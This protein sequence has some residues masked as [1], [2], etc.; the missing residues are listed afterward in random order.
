MNYR[1]SHKTL[2][3]VGDI[4]WFLGQISA[5]NRFKWCVWVTFYTVFGPGFSSSFQLYSP[6]ILV[7]SVTNLLEQQYLSAG[8]I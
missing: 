3:I 4:N 7:N 5:L 6:T 8:R 2:N 1:V